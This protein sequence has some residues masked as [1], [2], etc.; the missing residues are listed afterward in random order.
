MIGESTTAVVFRKNFVG[1]VKISDIGNRRVIKDID[2]WLKEKYWISV[3]ISQY[4]IPD[5]NS[6][7][8]LE[9]RQFRFRLVMYR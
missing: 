8:V 9:H 1:P 2:Y 7:Y 6:N 3:E 4:A 5:R